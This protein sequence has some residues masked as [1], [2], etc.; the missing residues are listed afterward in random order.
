[1]SYINKQEN[2]I[3][4]AKADYGMAGVEVGSTGLNPIGMIA[5]WSAAHRWWVIAAFVTIL[6]SMFFVMSSFETKLLD[7]YGE[8]ESAIGQKLIVDGFE[9]LA[10]PTEQLVFSNP[11]IDADSPAF[12]STVQGLVDQLAGLPEVESV[13]SYYD[14]GDQGM[15]SEDGHVVLAQVVVAG[16]SEEADDKIE[17]ILDAVY[18]ANGGEPGFEI[19]M[20]GASSLTHELLTI[21]EEDFASMILITMVLALSL[22]LIAFRGV[23]AAFIPLVVAIGSI[24]TALGIAA[25]LSQ[26]YPTIEFLA[27]IVLMIGMAVGIDYSLFIVSRYRT[28]RKAGRSKLEAVAFASNTTGR[29]VFYAGVTVVLSLVG[30]MFTGSEMFVAMSVGVIIVVLVALVASLTMLPAILAVLGDKVDALRLPIIGRDNENG[31]GI[32]AAMTNR[33]LA[34]PA[35]FAGVT[36]AILLA[37]AIPAT[38][39]ELSIASGSDALNDAVP[40]KKAMQILEDNFS[41][42]LAAPAY[43]IVE[44]SDVNAPVINNSVD[45]LV[46]ALTENEEFTPPFNVVKNEAGNLLYVEVPTVAGVD[47]AAVEESV[48]FL[49][50]EI[51]PEAF[52]GSVA[53]TYVGGIAGSV[54]FTDQ[55][56]GTAPYVVAFILGLAFLLLLVMFRSIVIPFKAIGLNLLSVGAA[57]GVV[58]MVFQWGWGIGLLGSESTGVI[59]PWLPM[60]LFAIL[61]GLSMDYHMLLLNRIK[62]S[63]DDGYSNEESVSRGIKFTAGQI[64][65]AAAI[66]VGVFGT[67]ALG[68]SIGTQQMGLGLSVAVLIDATLIRTVLLPAS[69]K[70]LGDR[71]W[72]LPSWLEWLPNLSSSESDEERQVATEAVP[73]MSSD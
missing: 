51:V 31:G 29:A 32:W 13:V 53:N 28:E 71:N 61:F 41:A 47:E 4:K 6:A 72:Y 58:V 73:S 56:V 34:K 45:K 60:F 38:T 59:E 26:V 63:Y 19:S 25:L 54:D 20:V 66:M 52:A 5:A 55:M 57:Y 24:F 49:R 18:S 8:G 15:V 23:V 39:L 44:A 2:R 67:F 69:M 64:T 16:D 35:I 50:S 40:G 43:V 62:E 12:R 10:P 33:V 3:T 65:S 37:V 68:R 17:A 7:Y 48:R 27:Q 42:G 1:M 11:S 30:L 46:L 22:M 14:T 9:V 36:T 21:D 70:L